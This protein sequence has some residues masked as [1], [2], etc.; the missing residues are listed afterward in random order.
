MSRIRHLAARSESPR[1]EPSRI[2]AT[3]AIFRIA[4][5]LTRIASGLLAS[6]YS[7][8]VQMAKPKTHFEQ[9]PLEIVKKIVGEEIPPELIIKPNP[10]NSNKSR[11]TPFNRP[12]SKRRRVTTH[13][14]RWS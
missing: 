1:I 6:R 11:R 12:N 14:S 10:A 4:K 3:D 9:V 8:A 2:F 13:L 7:E 5:E